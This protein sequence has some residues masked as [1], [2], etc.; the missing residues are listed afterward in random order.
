[1]SPSR[2]ENGSLSPMKPFHLR[3]VPGFSFAG[4]NAGI[5]DKSLD[6]AL[7]FS[8][9][10]CSAAA[11]FT[12]NTIPGAA[13]I[14]GKRH[15]ANGIL[16]AVVVNSKNAN[17]ATGF[18]GEEN[19]RKV[20]DVIASE[21]DILGENV[22]PGSTGVIGVPLP[23]DKILG[24]CNL[25]VQ[26]LG[27][28]ESQM[29]AFA[30]AI[31]T[32][33]THPKFASVKVGGATLVGFAK[34]A[35]MI[36]PNMATMLTYFFTDARITPKDL[37]PIL[38]HSV[39]KTFNRISVDSDTST[40]DTVVVLANGLAGDV[41]L[42]EFE[43]ALK[44]M[45]Q[46]LAKEIAR[47]GEGATKLVELTVSGTENDVVALKFARS[48]INSPLIKTAI[49]GADPNWGRFVMAIGKVFDHPV[50][51]ENISLLFG[52]GENPLVVS[53]TEQGA[54]RLEKISG[55]MKGKEILIEVSLGKGLGRETVWGCDLSAEYVRVNA[56][57]TT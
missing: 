17:V 48:I 33:D 24:A 25:I 14:V 47:D 16:Q 41:D 36:E 10:P 6:F 40:S 43:A 26:S 27:S 56:E 39:E 31:M 23:L 37:K 18:K 3:P 50:D 29:E 21:L 12:K 51:V 7:A 52:G 55:Y 11:V 44:N 32:T 1:M 45:A 4:V 57:Y 2:P 13:L 15:L 46:Y 20:C 35:G 22:F 53:V 19:A 34:G 28:S 30:R 49:H 42:M 54:D 5:K 9:V 8:E 38:E